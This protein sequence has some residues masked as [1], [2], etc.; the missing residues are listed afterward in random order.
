MRQSA[1]KKQTVTEE[2]EVPLFIFET[3]LVHES[4]LVLGYAGSAL[5]SGGME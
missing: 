3:F 4:L 5:I 2:V 1:E